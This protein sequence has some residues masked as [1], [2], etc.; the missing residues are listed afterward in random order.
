MKKPNK[1]KTAALVLLAAALLCTVIASFAPYSVEL[2]LSLAGAFL[3]GYAVCRIT[4][5]GQRPLWLTCV[6]LVAVCAS[7]VLTLILLIGKALGTVVFIQAF[8]LCVIAAECFASFAKKEGLRVL[9]C[10]I[11]VITGLFFAVGAFSHI[12]YVRS[13]MS[14]VAEWVL[15]SGKVTDDKVVDVIYNLTKAG[16]ASYTA[17]PTIFDKTLNEEKFKDISVLYLNADTDYDSVVSTF[18]LMTILCGIGSVNG[19]FWIIELRIDQSYTQVK[20][21]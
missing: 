4:S 17:D 3:I 16:E 6:L 14:T 1:L 19:I 11:V 10:V 8:N 12:V 15:A 5:K 9:S 2:F 21:F 13:V 20:Q 7:I 18:Y